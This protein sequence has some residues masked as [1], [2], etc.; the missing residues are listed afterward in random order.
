MEIQKNSFHSDDT[1]L[2]LRINA[3]HQRSGCTRSRIRLLGKVSERDIEAVATAWLKAV[4][5]HPATTIKTSKQSLSSILAFIALEKKQLPNNTGWQEFVCDYFEFFISNKTYSQANLKTRIG[6]WSNSRALLKTLINMSATDEKV[7]LPKTNHSNHRYKSEESAKSYVIG[8]KLTQPIEYTEDVAGHYL[9]DLSYTSSK[10][11][12]LDEISRTISIRLESFMTSALKYLEAIK[13]QHRVGQSLMDRI[14]DDELNRRITENN[15]VQEIRYGEKEHI[16]LSA[17]GLPWMLKYLQYFLSSP[18][19]IQLNLRSIAK[20]PLFKSLDLEDKKKYLLIDELLEQVNLAEA[21]EG[22]SRSEVLAKLLGLL[23]SRDCACIT[24]VLIHEHPELTSG[25][26]IDAKFSSTRG[27]SFLF[28]SNTRNNFIFSSSKPRAGKRMISLLSETAKDALELVNSSTALLRA[29]QK[30]NSPVSRM[31]FLTAGKDGYGPAANIRN[32]VKDKKNSPTLVEILQRL[33]PLTFQPS[34]IT[35]SR[36]RNSKAI[37]EWLNT[38]S[39]EA[40]AKRLA[41]TPSIILRHYLPPWLLTKWNE[42]SVRRFQQTIILLAAHQSPWLLEAS[43]FEDQESLLQ[44][45]NNLVRETVSGDPL[46]DLIL[47][48]LVPLTGVE[49][50]ETSNNMILKL[51]SESLYKIYKFACSTPTSEANHESGVLSLSHLIRT[52][53]EQSCSSQAE[54]AI[55]SRLQGDSFDHI[56]SMHIEAVARLNAEQEVLK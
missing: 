30:Q 13:D 18:N 56:R 26:V 41:N 12:Y 45:I 50:V 21:F 55:R 8:E 52:T 48:R 49:P 19:P 3:P 32:L 46:S 24:G 7:I 34:L 10:D 31:L 2:H 40:M 1:Y 6:N 25:A 11:E 5:G 15:F 33:H 54:L 27:K 23:H 14:S 38:G 39:I 22:I 53:I 29:G 4:E 47:A 36:I 28:A 43:D 16:L 20:T 17:N 37:L 42:R 9:T 44:Y 51:S 35:F